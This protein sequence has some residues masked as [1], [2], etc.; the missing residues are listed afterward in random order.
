MLVSPGKSG[1]EACGQLGTR[2]HRPDELRRRR[3][4]FEH[5]FDHLGEA[6]RTPFDQKVGALDQRCARK[7]TLPRRRLAPIHAAPEI[8]VAGDA[9]SG[10]RVDRAEAP[11]RR[12]R[13]LVRVDRAGPGG[14]HL[15]SGAKAEEGWDLG[16]RGQR[17]RTVEGGEV[18][19][20]EL[21]GLDA[22]DDAGA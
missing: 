3:R 18:R 22:E 12:A 15:R 21:A 10:L 4:R 13:C 8:R 7:S 14:K 2:G 20:G 9:D 6:I 17:L 5:S 1:V 19:G 11:G 16:D